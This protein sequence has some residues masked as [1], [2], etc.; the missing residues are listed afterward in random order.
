VKLILASRNVHK[1]R[2]IRAILKTLEGLDLWSLIDFPHYESPK[3]KGRTFKDN[4]LAK[5]RH[6]AKA[7]DALVLADDSGLVV[8]ALQGAPGIGSHRYAG[9]NATDK[10]RR[11]KLLMAMQGLEEQA[12]Q[13]YFECWLALVSP[14]GFEYTAKGIAEGLITHKERGGNGF[15]YDPIFVKHEYRKTFAE[16]EEA[17]KNRI[18]HR[19]RAVDT[20][21][22]LLESL[23]EKENYSLTNTN[24]GK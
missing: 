4:A 18:S 1:I 10:D 3:E 6:A 13:A 21:I 15:G 16:L 22:P 8:P 5:A 24:R 23:L 11:K 12:R 2:E 7:L 19:R 14:E 9:E 20:L 17:T